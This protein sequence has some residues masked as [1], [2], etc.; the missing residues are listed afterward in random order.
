M[1]ALIISFI[2]QFGELFQNNLA[3]IVRQEVSAALA[4]L[5]LPEPSSKED[6]TLS[7]EETRAKLDCCYPT[8]RELEKSGKLVPFRVGR[9]VKYRSSDVARFMEGRPA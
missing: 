2:T 9:S 4:Q 5:K 8:L 3:H 1:E 6:T 7:R